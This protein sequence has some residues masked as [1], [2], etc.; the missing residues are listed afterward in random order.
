MAGAAEMAGV[1]VC[2]TVATSSM[3]VCTTANIIA[4]FKGRRLPRPKARQRDIPGQPSTSV[5]PDQVTC[6]LDGKKDPVRIAD[7]GFDG[8]VL[9]CAYREGDYK[10]TIAVSGANVVQKGST[11]RIE[12]SLARSLELKFSNEKLAKQWFNELSPCGEFAAPYERIDELRRC[13]LAQQEQIKACREK[14]KR[15]GDKLEHNVGYKDKCE[16]LEIELRKYKSEAATEKIKI[17][18]EEVEALHGVLHNRL[19]FLEGEIPARHRSLESM[20][21]QLHSRLSNL[22]QVDGTGSLSSSNEVESQRL[23]SELQIALAQKQEALAQKQEI[24]GF[25]QQLSRRIQELESKFVMENVNAG[26]CNTRGLSVMPDSS[27][28]ELSS[29]L[30]EAESKRLQLQA[31]VAE[32]EARLGVAESAVPSFGK[33]A[34]SEE[35]YMQL[36]QTLQAIEAEA[37]QK[38][39]QQDMTIQ[40]LMAEKDI[41]Q[42]E[43]K[44]LSAQYETLQREAYR[45]KQARQEMESTLSQPRSPLQDPQVPLLKQDLELV[46][47]K[48]ADVENERNQAQTEVYKLQRELQDVRLQC[49]EQ[50]RQLDSQTRQVESLQESDVKLRGLQEEKRAV[51]QKAMELEV[52]KDMMA[53]DFQDMNQKLRMLEEEKLI[54]E[55]KAMEFEASK[56]MMAKEFE[57]ELV[58]IQQRH[59]EEMQRAQDIQA[60]RDTHF[61]RIQVLEQEKASL[62]S[63]VEMVSAKHRQLETASAGRTSETS[64]QIFELQQRVM[65]AEVRAAGFEAKLSAAEQSKANANEQLAQMEQ[66]LSME[67]QKHQELQSETRSRSI[68]TRELQMST[69]TQ[70]LQVTELAQAVQSKDRMLD[71]LQENARV[72]D[73][74]LQQLQEERNIMESERNTIMSENTN[75]RAAYDELKMAYESSLQTV[76]SSPPM[77]PPLGDTQGDQAL[78]SKLTEQNSDLKNQLEL[79]WKKI[80]EQTKRIEEERTAFWEELEQVRLKTGVKPGQ[81]GIPSSVSK[82]PTFSTGPPARKTDMYRQASTES[83]MSGR[84]NFGAS[85]YSVGT[86]LGSRSTGAPVRGLA[87]AGT[88]EGG[89]SRLLLPGSGSSY[90]GSSARPTGMTYAQTAAVS[91]RPISGETVRALQGPKYD[92]AATRFT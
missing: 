79:T 43:S 24:E 27:T 40:A 81:A 18:R 52:S 15:Y 89:Q 4:A 12:Q 10:P 46:Q 92:T 68:E 65:D 20:H 59:N 6:F 37:N 90:G 32:L 71:Q 51:D 29:K 78:I 34:V 91:G 39:Q 28:A 87:S 76:Q 88:P 22:E 58:A 67:K 49:M 61:S 74:M 64:A 35:Q 14:L 44:Q 21:D 50:T 73:Q 36:Q 55:Q 7:L 62:L 69:R 13:V 25:A 83:S 86:G 31:T 56:D 9:L 8:E 75:L 23:R 54:I 30:Q 5:G 1:V 17:H 33:G 85:K 63:E 53:K 80:N 11:I 45:E 60:D 38:I 84:S 77:S 2:G 57:A 19:T 41:Y 48:V 72:K 82:P 66:V 47:A 70:E 3:V 42:A 16:D 26:G